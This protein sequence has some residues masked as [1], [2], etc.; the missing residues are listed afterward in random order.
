MQKAAD[1]QDTTDKQMTDNRQKTDRKQE[2]NDNE[3]SEQNDQ[4]A[5]SATPEE[6]HK[7]EEQPVDPEKKVVYLT[8]D[9]GPNRNSM[10]LLQV[11]KEYD[12]KATFFTLAPNVKQYPEATKQMAADGHALA[13]HGVTHDQHQFYAT[14]ESPVNEMLETQKTVEDVTGVK[15]FLIR[16]PY[17]SVPHLTDEQRTNLKQNGFKLWDWNVD[18][19]DWKLRDQRYVENV[20]EQLEKRAEEPSSVILLHENDSTVKHLLLFLDF[21]VKYGYDTRILTEDIEPYHFVTN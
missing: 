8:F 6:N 4:N 10:E 19:Y 12:M 2:T 1:M 21:L 17:G 9:D 16:T 20:I 13:L 18:S 3:E 14:P 15:S 11:L 7:Q 5:Q